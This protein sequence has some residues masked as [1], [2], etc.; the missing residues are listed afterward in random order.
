MF[1]HIAFVPSDEPP[2]EKYFCPWYFVPMCALRH[3][4]KIIYLL[5]GNLQRAANACVHIPPIFLTPP[6]DL[7]L[8]G[9]GDVE[10]FYMNARGNLY[11]SFF[12]TE[13][14]FQIQYNIFHMVLIGSQ[15]RLSLAN[16]PYF[17]YFPL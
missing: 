5:L 6:K 14:E 1:P 9:R 10:I 7:P 11:L 12:G 15:V 16:M 3:K 2:V 13:F 17:G 4:L 8:N